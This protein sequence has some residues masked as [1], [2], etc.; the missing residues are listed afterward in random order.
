LTGRTAVTERDLAQHRLLLLDEGHCLREQALAVC[1][2]RSRDQDAT[3]DFRATSLD[4]ICE[5][6][7][8]GLGC[9][10]LPALALPHLAE[11]DVRLQVRPLKSALAHR[12]VG[13]L[14]RASYPRREDLLV[15]GRFIQD[16]LPDSVQPIRRNVAYA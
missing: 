15:L 6:V 7:A 4:T 9:S 12:R 16:Q 3:D 11:R 5:M 13:L 8:A 1:G 14:W 10:L 2:D